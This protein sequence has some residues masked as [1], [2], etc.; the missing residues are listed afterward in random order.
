MRT[1]AAAAFLLWATSGAALAEDDPKSDRGLRRVPPQAAAPDPALEPPAKC[2]RAHAEADLVFA[3]TK[4]FD[5]ELTKALGEDRDRLVLDVPGFK[6][7]DAPARLTP[8]LS[9]IQAA[10]GRIEQRDITCT[11]SFGRRLGQLLALL[12]GRPDKPGPHAAIRPY[13]AILWIEKASGE[14]KQ[15]ELVRRPVSPPG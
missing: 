12:F 1:L 2:D 4:A 5:L 9:E 7:D 15:I 14:V 6:P 10:D 13:D 8:W 3:D 11:R